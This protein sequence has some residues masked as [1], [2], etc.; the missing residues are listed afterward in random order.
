MIKVGK[1]K[2]LSMSKTFPNFTKEKQ[3][4]LIKIGE[5]L[6]EELF[7]LSSGEMV[8]SITG[9]LRRSIYMDVT[10]NLVEVGYSLHKAPYAYKFVKVVQ[11]AWDNIQSSIAFKNTIN[12]FIKKAFV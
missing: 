1:I 8:R 7:I 4:C 5:L 11:M 2:H 10:D 9:N 6:V 12:N 3:K